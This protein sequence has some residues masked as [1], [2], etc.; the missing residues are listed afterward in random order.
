M[1]G[2][3]MRHRI[4]IGK[5]YFIYLF[6]VLFL[7]IVG[8]SNKGGMLDTVWKAVVISATLLYVLIKSKLKIKRYIVIP[9]IIY[10]LGQGIAIFSNEFSTISSFVNCAIIIVMTYMFFSV[11][12][13]NSDFTIKDMVWF[14]NAFIILMLYAVVLNFFKNPSSVLGTLSN[15]NVYSN[16]MSSFFDNKQTFGM[17]LFMAFVVSVWGYILENKKCYI[18]TA[19]IFFVNLFLC[20]SRTALFACLGFIFMIVILIRKFNQ[21]LCR[22]LVSLIVLTIIL[23]Q[24]NP[25]LHHFITNVVLDTSAT[26]NAR[27]NIWEDA[28]YALNNIKFFW[29]YGEGNAS[30]AIATVSHSANAHN[31]IVYVLLTGGIIKLTLYI[32]VILRSLFSIKKIKKYNPAL[33]AMFFS[34][35]ASVMIYSMGEA[36]VL[37]DSSAPCVVASIICLAFPIATE[38]YYALNGEGAREIY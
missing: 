25:T 27:T 29:G 23:V 1:K 5:V 7:Q 2:C 37:L 19:M 9:L 26:M 10:I 3:I 31:G 13:Y 35:L 21:K 30:A 17:F 20:L 32:V 22:I 15:A 16:M 28:F 33:S 8:G 18:C 11:P 12:Y 36:L 6:S 38:G 4:N 24:L 14:L 34:A